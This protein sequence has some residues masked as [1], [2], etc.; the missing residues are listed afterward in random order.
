VRLFTAEGLDDV[1]EVCPMRG[2]QPP[3][4]FREKVLPFVEEVLKRLAFPRAPFVR[5]GPTRL[6]RPLRR[7]Q[8]RRVLTGLRRLKTPRNHAEAHAFSGQR[9]ARRE[10]FPLAST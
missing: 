4:D 5:S 2:R 9:W 1:S 8:P 10:R 7:D 3:N 6:P